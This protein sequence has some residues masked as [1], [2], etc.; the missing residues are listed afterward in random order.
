MVVLGLGACSGPKLK[1]IDGQTVNLAQYRDKV[2]VLNY[3]ASWCKP[4]WQEIPEL[5]Q[6]QRAHPDKVLVLGV[7]YDGLPKDRLLQVAKEMNIQFPVLLA[8]P[9]HYFQIDNVPGLPATYVVNTQGKVLSSHFGPQ[10]QAALEKALG[11]PEGGA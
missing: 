4:C 2:I 8:D 6:L 1:R 10:T 7:S 3:W 5:N 9:K 11:L